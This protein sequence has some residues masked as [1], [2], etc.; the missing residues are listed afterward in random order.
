MGGGLGRQNNGKAYLFTCNDDKFYLFVFVF[1]KLMFLLSVLLFY[2]MKLHNFSEIVVIGLIKSLV[3]D[4]WVFIILHIYFLVIL[5]S[6]RLQCFERMQILCILSVS[7]IVVCMVGHE[8]RHDAINCYK[9]LGKRIMDDFQLLDCKDKKKFYGFSPKK[10]TSTI[11]TYK[12]TTTTKYN[13]L[14]NKSTGI[15]FKTLNIPMQFA[16]F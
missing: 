3:S 13:R 4:R 10:S 1:V 6:F 11:T 12:T 14:I 8:P 15:Y 2:A 9:L 7:S 5:C 16:Y